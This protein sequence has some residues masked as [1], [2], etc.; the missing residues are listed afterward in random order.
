VVTASILLLYRY[1]IDIDGPLYAW[2]RRARRA[3]G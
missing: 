1:Y 2:R 3:A